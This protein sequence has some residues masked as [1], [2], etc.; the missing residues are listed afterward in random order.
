MILYE[1]KLDVAT[2]IE[3]KF[4]K[5]ALQVYPDCPAAVRV[6]IGL[7]CYKLGQIEK[8]RK[9]FQRVLQ[10]S[11]LVISFVCVAA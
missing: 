1:H 3:F 9:A 2:N 4:G 6:G 5:R 10:V 11:K 7:C 8:A